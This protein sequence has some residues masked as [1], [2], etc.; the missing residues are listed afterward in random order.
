MSKEYK[1]PPAIGYGVIPVLN[2]LSGQPFDELA[3]GYI[4]ALQP[5]FI[6]VSTGEIKCDCRDRRVTIYVDGLNIIKG[7]E[8]EANVGLY[9]KYENAHDL[10]Q[11]LFQRGIDPEYWSAE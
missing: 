8:I 1:Q 3:L 9:G 6:R 4:H 7:I 5:S 2:F 11:E 10:S